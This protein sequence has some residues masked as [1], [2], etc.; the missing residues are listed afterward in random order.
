MDHFY[1][2][3]VKSKWTVLCLHCKDEMSYFRDPFWAV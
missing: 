2:L 1:F 3:F